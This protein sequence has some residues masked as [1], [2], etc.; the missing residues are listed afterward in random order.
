MGSE[1]LLFAEDLSPTVL[2]H[3]NLAQL[4]DD[5]PCMTV[6][7][8]SCLYTAVIGNYFSFCRLNFVSFCGVVWVGIPLKPGLIQLCACGFLFVV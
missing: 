3:L 7:Y 6:S 1:I 4:L 2:K 8:L 5:H